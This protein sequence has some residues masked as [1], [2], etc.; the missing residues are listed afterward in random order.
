MRAVWVD[1]DCAA[2]EGFMGSPAVDGPNWC[3][4]ERTAWTRDNFF[5]VRHSRRVV[6]NCRPSQLF[7]VN[8]ASPECV[9]YKLVGQTSAGCRSVASA[10][11]SSAGC[12]GGRATRFSFATID[13]VVAKRHGRWRVFAFFERTGTQCYPDAGCNA[14]MRDWAQRVPLHSR[15]P[16]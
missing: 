1:H 2:A 14:V 7:D 10:R 15:G 6:G 9:Q 5:L 12:A 13:L 4:S 8:A 3:R 16:M 11:G